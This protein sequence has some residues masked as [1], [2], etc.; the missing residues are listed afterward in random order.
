MDKAI[1]RA[2]PFLSLC[3]ERLICCIRICDFVWVSVLQELCP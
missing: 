3:F 1:P 2:R